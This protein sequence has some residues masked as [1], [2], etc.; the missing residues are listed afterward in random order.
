SL[1]LERARGG[2]GMARMIPGLE[3]ALSRTGEPG[4]RELVDALYRMAGG[5]VNATPFAGAE[6]LKSRIY[7]LR[8][9]VTSGTRAVVVKRLDPLAARR[10]ERVAWRWLP[11]VNLGAA[12]PG[13]L[14]A[15]AT[16]DGEWVWHVYED[17][18]NNELR[19]READHAS[20]EAATRLIAR[21]HSRFA[22]HPPLAACAA[23]RLGPGRRRPDEL[24]PFDLPAAFS[25]RAARMDPRRLHEVAR[26]P[27][28]AAAGPVSPQP[29]VRDRRALALC[30]PCHLARPGHRP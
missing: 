8:F 7:R 14:G 3:Q 28:V 6:R 15:A 19:G 25:G 22:S 2:A 13:L 16:A 17:H 5:S 24:R 27:R 29:A 26:E 23:H 1:A 4:L 21:L 9:A 12:G 30:Q 20:V 10:N 11:A 18:G